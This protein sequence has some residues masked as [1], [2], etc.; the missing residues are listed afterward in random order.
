MRALIAFCLL[1]PLS[2]STV[3]ASESAKPETA[4]CIAGGGISSCEFKCQRLFNG[5]CLISRIRFASD[6]HVGDDA[7]WKARF[8]TCQNARLD[9]QV[10]NLSFAILP[11]QNYDAKPYL[12]FTAD[13]DKQS[14]SLK[15]AGNSILAEDDHEGFLRRKGF[16]RLINSGDGKVDL[17][18][19]MSG[20]GGEKG[21]QCAASG[22]FLVTMDPNIFC[23]LEDKSLPGTVK[24]GSQQL[25]PWKI[26][27]NN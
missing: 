3:A 5:V 20:C 24:F 14:A 27:L 6:G 16:A 8:D 9:L 18:F 15:L 25:R 1:L 21:E 10:E 19:S 17:A 11:N 26:L 7:F 12:T 22:T 4:T 2:V 13:T 23:E